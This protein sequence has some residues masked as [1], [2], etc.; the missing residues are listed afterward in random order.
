MHSAVSQSC[1]QEGAVEIIGTVTPTLIAGRLE[2]C[3]NGTWHAVYDDHW[4]EQDARLVCG[5][6]GFPPQGNLNT[7]YDY[8][9]CCNECRC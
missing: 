8:G 2:I 9:S 3:V 7:E 5:E 4:D 6:R 1:T